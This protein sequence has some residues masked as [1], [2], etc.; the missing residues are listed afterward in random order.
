MKTDLISLWLEACPSFKPAL[1]ES[2]AENGKEHLCVHAAAF[3]RHLLKLHMARRTE[4][5]PAVAAFIE[6]LHLDT[7]STAR[8]FATVGILESIQNVWSNSG[9]S[10]VE[11]FP[12]LLP[13]SAAAWHRLNR[14][15]SQEVPIISDA[16]PS[17]P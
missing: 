9:T 16:P 13:A 4:E 11:F 14:F 17:F 1:E 6:S 7:D 5:F 10:P 8:E 12:C 15:W 2:C 3:A